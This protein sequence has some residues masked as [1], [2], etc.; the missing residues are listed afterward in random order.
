MSKVDEH[1][2]ETCILDLIV[3][4]VQN[5]LL[6]LEELGTEK[7]E[8]IGSEDRTW[9]VEFSFKKGITVK[10]KNKEDIRSFRIEL[11]KDKQG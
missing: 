5:H 10:A 4:A 11:T 9:E 7:L 8:I 6:N 1:L 3:E 2:L